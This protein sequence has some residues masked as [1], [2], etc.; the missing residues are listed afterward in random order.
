M[1]RSEGFGD[2]AD[3]GSSRHPAVITE[4]AQSIEDQ[5]RARKRR[6]LFIMS[7]RIPALIL[8][9]I[10]YSAFNSGLIAILIIAVSVPLPWIAVL[11]ANDRPPRTKDEVSYYNPEVREARRQLEERRALEEKDHHTIE[12]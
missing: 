9:A 5:H 12:G 7:F 8:A 3:I 1:A 11:I 2:S 10:A 4:V 6:Y